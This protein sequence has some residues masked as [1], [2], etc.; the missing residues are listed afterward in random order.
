MVNNL[1]T[2]VKD[3]I[4]IRDRTIDCSEDTKYV[5]VIY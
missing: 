3:I 4:Q 5:S 1:T 2:N